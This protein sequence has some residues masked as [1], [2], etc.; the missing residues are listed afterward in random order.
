MIVL[1]L[2]TH[3][4]SHICNDLNCMLWSS[5]LFFSS[6]FVNSPFYL[7]I[8]NL[9]LDAYYSMHKGM[10]VYH[11]LTL[12]FSEYICEIKYSVYII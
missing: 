5:F 4:S 6:V 2:C 9:G 3:N 11:D 7:L 10:K 12:I 8:L 1:G